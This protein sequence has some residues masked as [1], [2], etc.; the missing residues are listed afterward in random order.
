MNSSPIVNDLA[1]PCGAFSPATQRLKPVVAALL[2]AAAVLALAGCKTT[3]GDVTG[4]INAQVAELPASPDAMQQFSDE[5]GKRYEA[6]PLNP[7]AAMNYGRALRGQG[8]TAQ[9]VAVLQ[10]AVLKHPNDLE[11][12][13]AYG[14]ALADSGRLKEAADVLAR[15]HTPERPNWSI[16]SAQGAVAD[17]LGDNAAAQRYYEAA[18]KIVPGDPLVMSNLGLSYALS[19]QL[20]RA[21]ETLREAAAHPRADRRVRQ[22]FALVLALEGK[23]AEA[24]AVSRRDLS[25]SEAA[26]NIASIRSMIAQSNTWREILK[27][28][29]ATSGKQA[30]NTPG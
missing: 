21:E 24:E 3:N 23:F 29:G 7:T 10:G 27:P 13:G 4:S 15:A 11:L 8:R 12:I 28:G 25:P 6:D 20:P 26:S 2:A 14:K 19:K 9:A 17:Q 1:T 5:W 18:L 16:L 30:A 22:N